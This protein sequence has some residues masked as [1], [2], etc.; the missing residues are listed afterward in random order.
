MD[1]FEEWCHILE[2][3][4]HEITMYFDYKNFQYFM[5]VRVLN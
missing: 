1:A 2:R 5:I 4:Q 3:V